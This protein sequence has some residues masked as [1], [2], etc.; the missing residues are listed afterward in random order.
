MRVRMVNRMVETW[1]PVNMLKIHH[2]QPGWTLLSTTSCEMSGDD[3]K[4]HF[5]V[6]SAL[7]V[8]CA[9]HEMQGDDRG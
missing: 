3:S 8:S 5:L 2:N 6:F 1:H 7:K 4:R 9:L